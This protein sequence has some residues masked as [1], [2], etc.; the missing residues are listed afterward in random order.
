M[1]NKF[2]KA[3]PVHLHG[4][5]DMARVGVNQCE[6]C[7]A[8]CQGMGSSVILDPWDVFQLTAR[9]HRN[10]EELLQDELELNV[11]DGLILPNLRMV[12]SEEDCVFLNG[13][14]RCSIHGFRPGLC[15][16]YPLGRQY[17]GEELRYFLLPEGCRQPERSKVKITRWLDVPDVETYQQYLVDW[18]SLRRELGQRIRQSTPQEQREWNMSLLQLF[19]FLPYESGKQE[20]FYPQFY[21]RRAQL[22]KLLAADGAGGGK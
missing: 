19:Y 12:G 7:H 9:L 6:G 3:D 21:Q 14:G 22:R 4:V 8:C 11:A 18:H 15:R 1:G 5:Q 16:A 17:E 10:M 2:Q 13:E 20:E